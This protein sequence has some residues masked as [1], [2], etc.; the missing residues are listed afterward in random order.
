MRL[1]PELLLAESQASLQL[2]PTHFPG[3]AQGPGLPE[4]PLLLPSCD[5]SRE[6]VLGVLL[7]GF[8]AFPLEGPDLFGWACLTL[9][10]GGSLPT[11]QT[12]GLLLATHR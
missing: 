7:P 2:S 3:G 8:Q 11:T 4:E 1:P 12:S 10:P 9:L 6:R 5:G